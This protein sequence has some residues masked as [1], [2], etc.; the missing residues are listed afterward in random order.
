MPGSRPAPRVD[1]RSGRAGAADVD[2]T[3][4]DEPI[5]VES[6]GA[7]VPTLPAEPASSH[8]LG[9]AGILAR[10]EEEEAVAPA[11]Q[12]PAD[13]P[14]TGQEATTMAEGGPSDDSQ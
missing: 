8:G 4:D 1:G 2:A 3:D 7:D 13:R 11:G 9:G 10:D 6:T 12:T 5:A 14:D